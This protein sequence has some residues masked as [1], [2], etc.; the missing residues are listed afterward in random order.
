M[1]NPC[2]K[3]SWKLLLPSDARST[4]SSINEN[5][6]GERSIKVTGQPSVAR[7]NASPARPAVVSSMLGVMPDFNPMAFDMACP[8]PPPNCCRCAS[9]PLRKS[10]EIEVFSWR[11]NNS[12]RSSWNI[13]CRS[14]ESLLLFSRGRSFAV[15]RS[16]ACC[17]RNFEKQTT[18][19]VVWLEIVKTSAD[20]F[21]KRML[22][23]DNRYR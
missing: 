12:T 10:I 6:T 23:Y 9:E 3:I 2:F 4:A 20:S 1:W 14:C 5:M 7:T 19:M 8:R 13:N 11:S 15:Q 22:D 16:F 18:A 21:T 17:R